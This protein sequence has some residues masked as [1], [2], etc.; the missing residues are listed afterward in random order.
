MKAPHNALEDYCPIT[1][2]AIWLS[3]RSMFWA[4]TSLEG[5]NTEIT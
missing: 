1:F 4:T 5:I 3:H 2:V